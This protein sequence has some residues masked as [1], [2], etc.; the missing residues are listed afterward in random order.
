ML[1]YDVR[2]FHVCACGVKMLQNENYHEQAILHRIN[3]Q[4]IEID[5]HTNNTHNS[6]NDTH[7]HKLQFCVC[8]GIVIEH[9]LYLK[10][11]AKNERITNTKKIRQNI[12]K[13]GRKREIENW[14]VKMVH[15][16]DFNGFR[17]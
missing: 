14:E 4:F 15:C 11:L 6:C 8:P 3:I 7:T 13:K 17:Q 9:K 12:F 10:K 2:R 1:L 5:W 16:C